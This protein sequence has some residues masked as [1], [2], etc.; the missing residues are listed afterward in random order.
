MPLDAQLEAVLFFKG[1]PVSLKRLSEL[2][3][4][5]LSDIE[6]GLK[7]LEEKLTGRGLT[8]IWKND[9]SASSTASNTAS[10][11]VSGTAS[12]VMLGTA[13]EVSE[14]IETLTR[15]DLTRDLGKAGLETLSIVLYRGPISRREID[16]I[17]GVNSTFI[18]RNLLIRG[19]VEKTQSAKDQRA[20][21]YQPTFELLSFMGLKRIEDMPEYVAMRAEVEQFEKSQNKNENGGA[22]NSNTHDSNDKVDSNK[23]T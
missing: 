4:K 17:R 12:E 15:E 2:L 14:I 16:Y 1:E 5:P 21:L 9:N 6:I 8:L 7:A 20:F 23:T 18:L 13:P 3:K 22:E 10:D 11:T 19:L